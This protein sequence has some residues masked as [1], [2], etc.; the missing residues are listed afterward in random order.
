MIF[1]ICLIFVLIQPAVGLM[2]YFCADSSSDEGGTQCQS[3]YRTMKYYRKKAEDT[4]SFKTEKYVKNCTNYGEGEVYCMIASVEVRKNIRSYIRDCSDGTNFFSAEIDSQFQ[5]GVIR[6]DN[7]TT[8]K[9]T[10]QGYLACVTVC[11]S[12]FGFGD[13]CNGPL[14]VSAASVLQ[15]RLLFIL[16]VLFFA[17]LSLN[18]YL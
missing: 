13:F 11:G 6:P 14:S 12:E 9:Y 15:T 10:G 5:G 1:R 2:C 18:S 8:C 3:W 16:T 7:Q 17:H 4:G